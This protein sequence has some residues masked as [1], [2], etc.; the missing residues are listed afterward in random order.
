[1][2]QLSSS[3]K[4]PV[5]KRQESIF[6]QFGACQIVQKCS[7]CG[8]AIVT[9]G[10]SKKREL[11]YNNDTSQQ[12][13][14]CLQKIADTSA[15]KSSSKNSKREKSANLFVHYSNKMTQ[16]CSECHELFLNKCDLQ[17]HMVVHDKFIGKG[18]G[19]GKNK[20]NCSEC[21]QIFFRKTDLQMHRKT[22]HN[23]KKNVCPVC[24]KAFDSEKRLKMH[25][26]FHN[27]GGEFKCYY[28]QKQ[29]NK[30]WKMKIH[31]VNHTGK[32]PFICQ[33]CGEDFLYPGKIAS[34]MKQIHDLWHPCKDCG[35][36][37]KYCMDYH[38]H[39]CKVYC[40]KDCTMCFSSFDELATHAKGHEDE[41]GSIVNVAPHMPIAMDISTP[42]IE[43][44]SP[45]ESSCSKAVMN[46]KEKEKV[47]DCDIIELSDI[48]NLDSPEATSADTKVV[49]RS[50]KDH[51]C[52]RERKIVKRLLNFGQRDEMGRIL[53]DDGR[54]RGED[55]HEVEIIEDPIIRRDITSV[56]RERRN[57][58]CETFIFEGGK[59]FDVTMRDPCKPFFGDLSLESIISNSKVSLSVNSGGNFIEQDFKVPEA[60]VSSSRKCIDILPKSMQKTQ[61][62]IN[63]SLLKK[64]LGTKFKICVDSDGRRTLKNQLSFES[65]LSGDTPHDFVF[66]FGANG[67]D[68]GLSCSETSGESHCQYFSK[69]VLKKEKS[70]MSFEDLCLF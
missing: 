24:K 46:T 66:G 60:T 17:A 50:F 61:E 59:D 67:R 44:N 63:R 2:N 42:K 4:E 33:H 45:I 27:V 47:D 53:Q 18:N 51:P 15:L 6:K 69:M 54:D 8:D 7:G 19:R 34:H 62:E 65:W 32:P 28:C 68:R 52:S 43:G 41:K 36:A 14:K 39:S 16:S 70:D 35:E 49:V 31:L 55:D 22:V 20:L 25:S 38:R 56:F 11:L 13:K 10:S 3:K 23:K 9:K 26:Q 58:L 1:M 21:S 40:C 5:I 57:S 48:S 12:C 64:K 30:A 37:F 29:F